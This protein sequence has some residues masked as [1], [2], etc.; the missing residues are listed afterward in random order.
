M[1]LIENYEE[2]H[3]SSLKRVE[4]LHLSHDLLAAD[5][6]HNIQVVLLLLYCLTNIRL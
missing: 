1:H 2:E 5:N 4:T 3:A 6:Y